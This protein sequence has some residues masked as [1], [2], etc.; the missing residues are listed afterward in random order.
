MQAISVY[1]YPNK[2]DVYTN[3]F[4]DWTTERYRRVYNRNLK[5]YRGVDNRIDLQVR[6]ADEKASITTGATLVFNIVERES[7]KIVYQRDCV[8]LDHNKG[9]HYVIIP[10]TDLLDLE[11]GFFQYSVSSEIRTNLGND[12][13]S[14]SSR[15]S[16]YS[17]T[18]YEILGTLE[19]LGAGSGDV[20]PSQVVNAFQRVLNMNTYLTNYYTSSIIPADILTSTPQSLHTFQFYATHF[21]G[22]V[23]IQG[24][25]EESADPRESSWVDIPNSAISPGTNNFDPAMAPVFYKNVV[26]KWAYFRIKHSATSNGTAQFVIQQTSGGDY[27]CSVEDGGGGYVAGDTIQILGSDLGGTNGVNDLNITVLSVNN[28]G[29]VVS[30]SFTGVSINNHRTFVKGASQIIVNGIIDKVLYR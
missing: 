10:E 26:G 1:L 7:Q 3:S 12:T 18:Q 17:D 5:I 24:S 14:V 22:K 29:S 9:R 25:L 30:I 20:Q 23:T 4:A 19:I 13:Y 8:V 27:L 28:V 15:T 16:L 11:Q 2:I 6:N 21:Q